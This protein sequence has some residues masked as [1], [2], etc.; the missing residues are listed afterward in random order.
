MN[1]GMSLVVAQMSSHGGLRGMKQSTNML[2]LV[3]PF[4][5]RHL[6]CQSDNRVIDVDYGTFFDN[7]FPV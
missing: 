7:A 4:S 2:L 6:R 1:G 5:V 3:K